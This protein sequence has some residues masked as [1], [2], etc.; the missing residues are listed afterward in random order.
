MN[1]INRNIETIVG[2]LLGITTVATAFA[3]FAG[4]LWNSTSVANYSKAIA[5][6]NHSNTLYLEYSQS[7]LQ[8]QLLEMQMELEQKTEA[9]IDTASQTIEKETTMLKKEYEESGDEAERLMKIADSANSAND[10]FALAAALYA[11]ILFLGSMSL[12]VSSSSSKVFYMSLAL[13]LFMGVFLWMLFLPM[14]SL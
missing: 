3:T 12:L 4:G 7:F 9:E 14:P 10:K 2:I 6:I 8:Q 13:C 1:F 5:E 11:I